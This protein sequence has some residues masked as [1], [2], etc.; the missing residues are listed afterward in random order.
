MP[1]ITISDVEYKNYGRCK[2]ISNGLFEMYVTIDLGPRI[3]KLNLPGKENLMFNDVERE[4][5]IDVSKTFGSGKCW[6]IYG[7]HRMWVSPED[8]PKTYYPD[9]DPVEAKIEG[10]KVSFFPGPQTANNLQ[11]SLEISMCGDKPCAKVAHKLENIGEN[12]ITGAIW[13]MSVVAPG[14]TV[15]CPQ[16]DED[17]GL[18]G[19]RCMAFWPY[20]N[21]TDARANFYDRYITV[22]QNGAVNEKFK[23]GINNTKGWLAYQ[24]HGQIFVKTY[25][26]NHPAGNYPD[27][28]MSTEV[29][30][31]H[32]FSEAETL[33]EL[34][35]LKRGEFIE[36][37]ETWRL[38]DSS[39]EADIDFKPGEQEKLD[40]YVKRHIF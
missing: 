20:T 21:L 28:G 32:L 37:A 3:I 34:K 15:I 16:P 8:M 33:S 38:I 7:G 2:A 9:N 31:N 13:A 39:A 19:N 22:K 18:L 10:N 5:H 23:F 6:Y 25:E 11:H 26:P 36:H 14:G 4:M 12:E 24:N 1:K 40:A 29:F 30:T 35:T 17:T 27:W